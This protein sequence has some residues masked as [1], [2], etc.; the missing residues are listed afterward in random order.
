MEGVDLESGLLAVLD[1]A[2]GQACVLR[3]QLAAEGAPAVGASLV[4]GTLAEGLAW[5]ERYRAW[6]DAQW[7]TGETP[8]DAL[9]QYL[10]G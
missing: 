2:L 8:E 7:A 10:R 1:V 9:E 3:E 4:A 5:A 6:R